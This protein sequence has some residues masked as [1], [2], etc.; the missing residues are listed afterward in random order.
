MKLESGQT[1]LY[2]FDHR[3]GQLDLTC[4]RNPIDNTSKTCSLH[5]GSKA[6]KNVRYV[7]ENRYLIRFAKNTA[8][9]H[10][11]RPRSKALQTIFR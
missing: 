11:V 2:I 8:Q 1:Q 3:T 9:L 6:K 10:P 5:E 4:H 7:E